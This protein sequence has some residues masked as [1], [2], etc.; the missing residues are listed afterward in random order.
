METNWETFS[1]FSKNVVFQPLS[2]LIIHFHHQITETVKHA[3]SPVTTAQS[4]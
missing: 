3:T 4:P 2:A 1:P